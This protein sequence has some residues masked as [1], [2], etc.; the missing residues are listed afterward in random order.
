MDAQR[1]KE[2]Y[3][4]LESLDERSTHKIR[5]KPAASLL[6]PSQERMEEQLRDLATY[7]LELK[8]ILHDM[9]VAIAG[10]AKP[11]G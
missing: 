2:A 8:E 5:P 7:T 6:R 1:F 4:R 10:T 11:A 3:A 9:F